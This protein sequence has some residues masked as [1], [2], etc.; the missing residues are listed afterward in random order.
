[1]DIAD[2]RLLSNGR[3]VA[4]SCLKMGLEEIMYESVSVTSINWARTWIRYLYFQSHVECY[5]W[6][7]NSWRT[8]A[9]Q[10]AKHPTVTL[11]LMKSPRL[12]TG[13]FFRLTKLRSTL[14]G[15]L[16][17]LLQPEEE[18]VKLIPIAATCSQM[19]ISPTTG[20]SCE[21]RR[22]MRAKQKQQ[23]VLH[24]RSLSPPICLQLWALR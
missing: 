2:E 24:S 16:A 8:A 23:Q 4:T 7:V 10:G 11:K 6:S 19:G 12:V 3:S 14:F 20:F 22:P 21:Q 1:M 17:P 9:W 5:R 18:K 15:N 13:P